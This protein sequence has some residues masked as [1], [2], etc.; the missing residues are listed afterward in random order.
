MKNAIVVSLVGVVLGLAP[1]NSTARSEEDFGAFMILTQTRHLKLWFSGQAQNWPL[2]DYQIGELNEGFE[3]APKIFPKYRGIEVGPMLE[4]LMN[5][6]LKA[7]ELAIRN[8]SQ[9]RFIEA[10]DRLTTACNSCHQAANRP[11]I[12]IQRPAGISPFLNQSFNAK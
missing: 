8:H 10:Y 7:V 11:F 2:A 1:I 12:A 3:D 6:A 4:K 5:P 9:T